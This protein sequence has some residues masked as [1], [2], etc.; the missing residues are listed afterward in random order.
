VVGAAF[1]VFT[2]SAASSTLLHLQCVSNIACS[3]GCEVKYT[4]Y[5]AGCFMLVVLP[6][7]LLFLLLPHAGRHPDGDRWGDRTT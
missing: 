2:C 1:L 5:A 3:A 4:L 6:P 7:Y